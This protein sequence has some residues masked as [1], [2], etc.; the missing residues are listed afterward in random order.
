MNPLSIVAPYS[1]TQ[2]ID[3]LPAYNSNYMTDEMLD[4]MREIAESG[5]YYWSGVSFPKG[6]TASLTIPALGTLNG[7]VQIPAGSY[8]TAITCY[9]DGT[10][11]PGGYKVSLFD[12]GSKSSLVY[13]SYSLERPIMSNMQ[14]QYGVGTSFPPSDQGSNLDNPFGPNLLLTPFIITPP[15]LLNWEVVSLDSNV[16]G[17]LVQ[18]MLACAIPINNNTIGKRQIVRG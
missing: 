8:V 5:N 18:V 17:M 1:I 14:A 3:N 6:A 12:K 11:N 13:G 16:A 15:G 2:F 10:N 7:S 9:N 4:L